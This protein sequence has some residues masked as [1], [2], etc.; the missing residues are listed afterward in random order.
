MVLL[1]LRFVKMPMAHVSRRDLWN[2]AVADPG[3]PFTGPGIAGPALMGE[4]VPV[5]RRYAPT[6]HQGF[7]KAG[8][9]GVG[10]GELALSLA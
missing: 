10:L 5:L 3:P 6:P 2:Y 8:F 9:N 7:E 1:Q 4:L